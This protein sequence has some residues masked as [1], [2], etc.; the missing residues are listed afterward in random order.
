M[1][2]ES[3]GSAGRWEYAGCRAANRRRALGLPRGRQGPAVGSTA[4]PR[5]AA[6]FPQAN[7]SG[8]G[9]IDL[10]PASGSA[11]C[12]RPSIVYGLLGRSFTA[13]RGAKEPCQGCQ[14]LAVLLTLGVCIG[15][16]TI[17]YPVVWQM[18]S[19][20]NPWPLASPACGAVEGSDQPAA[21]ASGSQTASRPRA[22]EAIRVEPSLSGP[23]RPISVAAEGDSPIFVGRKLGQSPPPQAR[24]V[25]NGSM[26]CLVKEPAPLVPHGNPIAELSGPP[27]MPALRWDSPEATI[28]APLVP[29]V[30]PPK[31]AA[32]APVL[33][34]AFEVTEVDRDRLAQ[35][36]V[37]CLPPINRVFPAERAS[38]Q[39]NFRPTRS[40]STRR[41]GR[42]LRAE[43]ASPSPA[44]R[45]L[46]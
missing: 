5:Q 29:I 36:K 16:N 15:F 12:P 32:A 37:R 33:T 4:G 1:N 42:V 45:R 13:I 23:I 46:G 31:P 8:G 30:R 28:A 20:S 26:C 10:P 9:R 7:R 34:T 22:C 3:R 41:R 25:C 19:Q 21:A 39:E 35:D 44:R 24:V 17:R 14:A 40:L 43:G 6:K 18:V 38:P 11:A 27:P 2:L